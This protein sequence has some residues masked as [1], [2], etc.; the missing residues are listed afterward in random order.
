M[1]PELILDIFNLLWDEILFIFLFFILLNKVGNLLVRKLLADRK[2]TDVSSFK[3]GKIIGI[4]ERVIV[5]L[6]IFIGEWSLVGIILA[7]KTIAR[8]KELDGKDNSEYFLIG[9]MASLLW[10]ILMSFSLL[11]IINETIYLE[12]MKILIPDNS[13]KIKW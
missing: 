11:L 7:L 3:N 1:I 2:T 5:F 8:Y 12:E 4:L 9:T 10:A 13:I 6:G